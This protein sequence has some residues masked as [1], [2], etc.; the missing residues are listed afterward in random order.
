MLIHQADVAAV[1]EDHRADRHQLHHLSLIQLIALRS[2]PLTVGRA[3]AASKL[4]TQQ[5]FPSKR[6]V[7]I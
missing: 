2:A 1:C 3:A 7:L 6:L 4:P 5:L